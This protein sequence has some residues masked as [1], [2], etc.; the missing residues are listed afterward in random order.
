QP[1]DVAVGDVAP[2]F[3]EMRGDA[4]GAG[5]GGR[6]RG[7][8]RIGMPPAAR[9]ADRGDVVDVD[10]EAELA[11]RH[12]HLANATRNLRACLRE[13]AQDDEFYPSNY[14]VMVSGEQWFARIIFRGRIKSRDNQLRARSTAAT[15]F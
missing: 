8:D 10:A 15:T 2:V 6:D 1:V 12:G 9:V 14:I 13:D 11:G 4:V 5:M 3:A 7:L